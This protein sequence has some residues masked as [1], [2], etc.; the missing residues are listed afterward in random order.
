[1]IRHVTSGSG[2]FNYYLISWWAR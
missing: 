2:I 1:M